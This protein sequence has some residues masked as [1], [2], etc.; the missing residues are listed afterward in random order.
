MEAELVPSNVSEKDV[1]EEACRRSAKAG[2]ST[3]YGEPPCRTRIQG[4]CNWG[5]TKLNVWPRDKNGNLI[6]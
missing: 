1:R 5:Q 2:Y 6:P 4:L 3:K